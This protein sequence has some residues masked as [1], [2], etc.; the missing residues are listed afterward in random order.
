[1]SNL[2][3]IDRWDFFTINQLI[4]FVFKS[5]CF[6]FLAMCSFQFNLAAICAHFTSL[7]AVNTNGHLI[8]FWSCTLTVSQRWVTSIEIDI[9]HSWTSICLLWNCSCTFVCDHNVKIKYSTECTLLLGVSC[10]AVRLRRLLTHWGQVTQ[11]CV[12]N[13]RLFSL[14]SILNYAMHRGCL[15]MVLLMDVYRN[16][17]SLSIKL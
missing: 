10:G 8:F 12:F 5:I 1:M 7:S 11:I 14:H 6:L 4:S 13:T 2:F 15:R 17:T 3:S 16:L 9:L